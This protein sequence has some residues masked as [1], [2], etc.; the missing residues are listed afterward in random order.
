MTYSSPTAARALFTSWV[1]RHPELVQKR[2]ATRRAIRAMAW[3]KCVTAARNGL[4][5][6]SMSARDY[7]VALACAVSQRRAQLHGPVDNMAVDVW[8]S[9]I[10][11]IA[12]GEFDWSAKRSLFFRAEREKPAME[13]A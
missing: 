6:I 2:D 3:R 8:W 4:Q 12:V 9:Q 7:E 1:S 11:E 5:G 10:Q 13:A